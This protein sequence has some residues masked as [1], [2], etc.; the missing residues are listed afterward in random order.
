MTDDKRQELTNL[1]KHPMPTDLDGK[2]KWSVIKMPVWERVHHE[3]AGE[4]AHP[5]E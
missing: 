4:G 5:E 3:S 2:G 1:V